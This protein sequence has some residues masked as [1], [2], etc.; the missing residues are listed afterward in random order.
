MGHIADV[1]SC[2]ALARPDVQFRL[3]HNQRDQ[4]LAC[5]PSAPL[6]RV[7]DVLGGDLQSSLYPFEYKDDFLSLSDGHQTRQ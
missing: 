6:D 7:I 4:K 5:C 3:I 1:V 2:C